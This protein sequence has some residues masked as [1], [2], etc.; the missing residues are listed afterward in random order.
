M[1]TN[2]SGPLRL[3]TDQPATL[4]QVM[5]RAPRPRPYA[6]GM[7]VD[8]TAPAT[9]EEG[10]VSFP[11]VPGPAV[12]M[13]SHAGVPQITVPLVVP[14]KP[15]ASLEECMQAAGL[16]DNATQSVLEDLARRIVEG[17]AT[18]EGAADTA[19]AQAEIATE[20]AGVASGAAQTATEQAGVASGHA[21]AAAGSAGAAAVSEANAKTS[22][23]EAKRAESGARDSEQTATEQA[24]VATQGAQT[25]TQQATI[26]TEQA[27]RATS[28]A[29][30]ATD[31]ADRAAQ[32][33]EESSVK[34]V[35]DRVND[36]LAGAPE[37]YDTLLEIAQELERG[38]SAEAALTAAIA[39]KAPLDHAHTAEQVGAAPASHT[40]TIADTTGL[41]GALDGKASSSHP[42]AVGD[43]TGLQAALDGKAPSSHS[44]AIADTTDLQSVLDGKAN[45]SQ[46]V[47]RLF[48]GTGPPPASI[49]GA[50]VGDWWLDTSSKNLYTITGV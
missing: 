26:A 44:H 43:V 20:Q 31:E 28:E 38:A 40:H 3:V 42:H 4:V 25:A 6:G 9:V 30:R 33:A 11:C 19:T 13:V 23:Q 41:Q 1:A 45:K 15:A 18:A 37:A 27:G 49:P 12:L 14:D 50:V 32:A 24:G 21:G 7:V 29:A 10:V 39:G 36:L 16:A 47:G 2:I 48:S 35:S 34:A 8:F 46:I 17:V 22:E 5:V